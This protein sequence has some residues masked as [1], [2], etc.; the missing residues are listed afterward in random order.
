MCDTVFVPFEHEGW[1]IYFYHVNKELKV[2]KEELRAQIEKVKPEL[3]FIHPYY[4]VD[5]WKELR[6]WLMELKKQGIC[7]MEDVTQSYYL[8]SAGVEADYVIGS[9]RKWYPV[10]DGGFV[11]SDEKLLDEAIKEDE[12]HARIRIGVLMDKWNYLYGNQAAEEKKVN[13]ETYLKRNREL[14]WQVDE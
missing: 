10:P 5:T 14:E 11:A 13:K 2:N 12:E 4:G 1:E 6:P 9:L 3:L 8:E 7:I